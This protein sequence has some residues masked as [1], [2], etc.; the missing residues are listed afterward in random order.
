[1]VHRSN[2]GPTLVPTHS[3]GAGDVPHHRR[4]RWTHYLIPPLD[5][6]K[7]NVHHPPF[8]HSH[9]HHLSP[10]SSRIS[11]LSAGSEGDPLRVGRLQC[12]RTHQSHALKLHVFYRHGCI[13]LQKPGRVI[14]VESPEGYP[15]LKDS[16]FDSARHSTVRHQPYPHRPARTISL[17]LV[18]N[19]TSSISDGHNTA[20]VSPS[21]DLI[22]NL[23][24]K[25]DTN[26]VGEMPSRQRPPWS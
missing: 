1:M 14:C 25:E 11:H 16:V 13:S 23:E 21:E 5:R 18:T 20:P 8:C 24:F 2:I 17:S 22:P 3:S 26:H 6:F 9:S 4:S 10:P 19:L 12:G 7:T 15:S